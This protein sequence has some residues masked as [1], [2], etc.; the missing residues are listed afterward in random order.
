MLRDFAR[1]FS[2]AA[3]IALLVTSGLAAVS[4]ASREKKISLDTDPNLVGWWKF[5]E[6]S[7]Q[8]AADFSG[9]GHNG[10]LKGGLSFEKDSVSGRMG[11]T[12]RLDGRDD[13]VEITGYKGV[14]GTR[15]RTVAAW[16]RTRR[17]V[18]EIVSWGE[19]DYGKMWIVGFIR[20]RVGATP[21]GGYLYMNSEVHD[22]RWHHVAVVVQSADRPNLHDHVKLYLDGAV[23]EIHDI[24]L[25]DLWPI[26]TGGDMDVRIG[27]GFNGLID[28]VLIYERALSEEEIR[29]SFI[30][31]AGPG[32]PESE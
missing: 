11:K 10:T 15:P 28:D 20:G 1:A 4:A 19:D 13:Y 30:L 7:G 29:A 27:R 25:L 2:V 3:V 32:S 6:V 8:T 31:K 21:K 17:P 26:E 22:D 24:G 9:R 14:S 18:G 5:D 23:A 16:I 12:L